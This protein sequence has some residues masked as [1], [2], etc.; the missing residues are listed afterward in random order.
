MY[1]FLVVALLPGHLLP[2]SA[3]RAHPEIQTSGKVR[4]E[5]EFGG[6]QEIAKIRRIPSKTQ[7]ARRFEVLGGKR[8]VPGGGNPPPRMGSPVKVQKWESE[9][10]KLL[11]QH[12]LCIYF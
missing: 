9:N 2:F 8:G 7:S 1:D 10:V 3:T 12:P 5:I 11:L 6:S 4:Q